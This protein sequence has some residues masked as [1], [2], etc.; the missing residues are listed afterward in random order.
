M[1]IVYYVDYPCPVKDSVKPGRMLRLLYARERANETLN[2]ARTENPGARPEDVVVSLSLKGEGGARHLR[3][4][5]VAEVLKQFAILERFSEHCSE[6]RARVEHYPF[7]CRAR[8]DFP[9]SFKAEAFLMG[10][11]HARENDP[12]PVLLCNYLENNGMVGTRT[13]EMRK[14]PGMFFESDKP[15]VRRFSDGRKLSVN[16]LFELLFLS[17]RIS[18]RHARFL[19]G[20]LGLYTDQLP[21]S[22]PLD[23]LPNLFVVEK[24]DAG[25]KI[26]R[27]GLTLTESPD[28]DRC[29]RQVQNFFGGLLLGAELGCDVWVKT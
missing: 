3:Q 7:G 29:T 23:H 16:Q 8:V 20:L 26:G 18:S 21:L 14:L 22:P 19:L 5:P 10:L 15:L 12:T 9:I 13:A 4:L 24:E 6:C 11:V 27:A 2:K 1:P 28:A 17:D 25:L